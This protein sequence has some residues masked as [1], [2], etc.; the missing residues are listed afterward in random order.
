MS[1]APLAFPVRPLRRSAAAHAA[2][3]AAALALLTIATGC[4]QRPAADVPQQTS[5]ASPVAKTDARLT[6]ANNNGRYH[7]EGVVADEATRRGLL[8]SLQSVYGGDAEGAIAIDPNTSPPPWTERLGELLLAFRVPG[9]MLELRGR[10]IELS[11]AVPDEDRALLLKKARELYPDLALTGLF[12]GVDASQALPDANDGAE[13]VAFLNRIPISFQADSGLVSPGSLDGLNRAARAIQGAT[14]GI[15]LQV[16]VHPE[17][18]DMPDYDRRI[19]FQRTNSVKVQLAIRGVSPGRLDAVVLDDV[20]T[21]KT[22]RVEFAIA[23]TTAA[24]DAGPDTPPRQDTPAT[25]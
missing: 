12:E 11:G 20:A 15:R 18:S 1:I 25:P 14:E 21:D 13:L 3:L 10:R 23:A 19:A 16:G 9:G 22:G 8:R 4:R 6:V 24:I 2:T 5:Q 17:R 7:F